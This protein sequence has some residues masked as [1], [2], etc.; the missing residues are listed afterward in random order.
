MPQIIVVT[1]DRSR[2][3][4]GW[5]RFGRRRVA[6]AL[7]R[8]GIRAA[9]REG[10]GATPAGRYPLRHVF[11]RPVGAGR[12][13]TRLPVSRIG[14]ADGWGDDPAEPGRYNRRV[15]LPGPGGHETL[16]RDDGLYDLVV[17]LGHNDR[18][19]VPGR[20]SA[21]FVHLARADGGP[22]AGCIA[23]ARADLL[24][25]LAWARPGAVVAIRPA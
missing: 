24:A 20:G 16:W 5:L 2:P 10:D 25:L 14:R 3:A 22:T 8:T 4:R 11:H 7:G 21:I 23:L 6:C 1:P 15:L 12:P 9:K 19:A 13:R 17:A 18:P